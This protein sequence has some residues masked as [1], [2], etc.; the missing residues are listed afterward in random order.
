[1]LKPHK[2]K[3][4]KLTKEID[5]MTTSFLVVDDLAGREARIQARTNEWKTVNAEILRLIEA[6]HKEKLPAVWNEIEE[7]IDTLAK[8]HG[9]QMVLGY[10]DPEDPD[11]RTFQ[12][13]KH[14]KLA[15]IDMGCTAVL[16]QHASVDIT[17]ILI[18]MLS[19]KRQQGKNLPGNR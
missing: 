5:E 8:T 16:Y 10:G 2:L 18:E 12:N 15:T 19:P 9:I 6:K 13:S 3:A 4:E 7:A 11:V 1:V 14:T 17:P